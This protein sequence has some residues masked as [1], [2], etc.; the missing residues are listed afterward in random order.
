MPTPTDEAL[1]LP[2]ILARPADEGPRL[3]YA[4]FLDESDDAA[5]RAR[6]DL[7]RVQC[8]LARMP[9]DHPRRE[10]LIGQEAELL[11]QHLPEWSAPLRDL[12]IG[13]EFRRGIADSVVVDTEQFLTRGE[14]LLREWPIRRVRFHDATQSLARLSLCPLLSEIR[15]LDFSGNDLGN[16]GV[17]ILLRSPFLR[18]VERLDLSFNSLSDGA[19][20]LIARCPGLPYLIDLGLSGNGQLSSEGIKALADSPYLTGLRVLDISGND[21]CDAGV[22]SIT[23]SQNLPHLHT[24]RVF[25]NH[26]G[27][28]GVAALVESPLVE[29]MLDHE[30]RLDLRHNAITAVGAQSLINSRRLTKLSQLNLSG[31]YLED[32]G[33]TTLALAE[34]LPRLRT[35]GLQQNQISDLGAVAL[36]RS[37]L[38]GQLRRIDLSGNRLTHKGSDAL[39]QNRRD[40]H[41]EIELTGNLIPLGSE[42]PSARLMRER[43]AASAMYMPDPTLDPS[44]SD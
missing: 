35:L 44:R 33:L 8:A 11:Q 30:P 13:M 16:G 5:D 38:M 24:F 36:T 28:A 4:D 14:R 9:D 12:V 7:I 18:D 41:T 2:A 10:E 29:R 25:S 40:F 23:T 31:N 37:A 27:D 39:W 43:N 3:I 42:S 17:N 26:I 22:R 34:H 20:R 21:V 15:E 32:A 6:A 19:A 1:F